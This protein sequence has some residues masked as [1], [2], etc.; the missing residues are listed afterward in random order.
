[1][2]NNSIDVVA[3]HQ[4]T[5]VD[6]S[7]LARLFDGEYLGGFGE[8]NPEQPYGYAA[9]G[10]H[11]VAR[12]G[13][14]IVGHVG[15]ARRRITVGDAVVTIAGVGGVL[16]SADGRGRGLGAEL[17]SRA[18]QSMRERGDIEFGYLG[19]REE[20]VPFYASCGWSRIHVGE[21]SIGRHGEAV[22]E[23][24]G[25]PILVLPIAAPLESWPSGDVD[26]RG[27]AW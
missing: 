19:C 5:T 24:P 10:V 17:M 7:R 4:L 15:W 23:S 6:L 8:W 2:T 26:L 21:Q 12:I 13:D 14:R 22:H 11:I 27:R 1:M 25:S 9:H 16:I 18:A 3:H 20:V